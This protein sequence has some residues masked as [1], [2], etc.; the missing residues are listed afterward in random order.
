VSWLIAVLLV[1]VLGGTTPRTHT[2][3]I[4]GMEFHPAELSVAAGDTVVWINRDIVPHTATAKGWGTDVLTQ[5]QAGRIVARHAGTIDYVCNL[6]PTMH[7][8]LLVRD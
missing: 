6:H 2:V 7:G 4:R 8:T 1:A 5:G 3:E